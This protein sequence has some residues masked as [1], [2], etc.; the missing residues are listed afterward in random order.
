MRLLTALSL[1]VAVALGAISPAS[2]DLILVNSTTKSIRFT[3]LF[4]SHGQPSKTQTYCLVNYNRR[5]IPHA[6]LFQTVHIA[7]Y[8]TV[9]A[10]QMEQQNCTGKVLAS[11]PGYRYLISN[12]SN[13]VLD[14]KLTSGVLAP[15]RSQ[16]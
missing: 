6:E 14:F 7:V 3:V 8:G 4:E 13:P 11:F 10:Q 5:F 9:V 1:G 12:G 15:V 16:Y 2:A